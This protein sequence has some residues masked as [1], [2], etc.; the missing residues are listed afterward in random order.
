MSVTTFWVQIQQISMAC[1]YKFSCFVEFNAP[2]M[3]E[4]NKIEREKK[5]KRNNEEKIKPN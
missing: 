5:L 4:E 1:L 2:K 3:K